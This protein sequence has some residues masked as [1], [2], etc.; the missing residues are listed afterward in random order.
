M[1]IECIPKTHEIINKYYLM[2]MFLLARYS[3]LFMPGVEG[4]K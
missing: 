4:M 3:H 1:D 2:V